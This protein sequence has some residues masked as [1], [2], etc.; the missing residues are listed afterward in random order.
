[1]MWNLYFFTKNIKESFIS[2][3]SLKSKLKTLFIPESRLQEMGTFVGYLIVG[4]EP[5]F[6]QCFEDIPH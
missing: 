5:V 2:Q 1:M 4:F 3:W 6:F